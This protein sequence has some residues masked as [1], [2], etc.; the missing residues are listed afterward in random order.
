M[1]PINTTAG[2]LVRKRVYLDD[3][4]GFGMLHHARYALLFDNAVLDFWLG[5]GW[6][7]DPSE[8]VLVIRD[9]QLRYHQPVVGLQEVD[10]HLW[11]ERA[12]R[13]SVSYRFEVLST[14]H[15]VRHADGSRV[16]V[17]LDPRSLRPAPLTDRMWEI[18]APLLGPGVE[19]PTAA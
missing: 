8:S 10:V 16:V 12:G 13:T 2:I 15:T 9:L 17:N 5:A 6:V 18:A 11:V 3:L 14:D 4:D 7:I 1:S 19:R